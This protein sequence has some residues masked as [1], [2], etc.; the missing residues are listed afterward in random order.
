MA[1]ETFD[2]IIYQA[3]VMYTGDTS[4]LPLNEMIR[5]AA[6]QYLEGGGGSS[7][8]PVAT[9][10]LYVAGRWYP[11]S[12]V[13]TG[14]VAAAS[15][16]VRMCPFVLRQSVT[17]SD[18]GA[19]VTIVGGGSFQLA[20][21]ANNAATMRPTGAVLARTGDILSTSLAAVSGDITGANVLLTA[22]VYWAAVNVDGAS[23]AAAFT[24]PTTISSFGAGLVGSETIAN[25]AA[26]ATSVLLNLTT[27][28]AYN[29]WSDLTAATFTEVTTVVAPSLLIK[30]A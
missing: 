2:E 14:G 26:T 16:T 15:G 12:P 7:G 6:I 13:I 18:L 5:R 25:V 28:L 17:V 3:A 22:G 21:Y 20:I 30:A 8:L 29:T 1:G 10:P 27:P 11:V 23:A 24:G 19:R 9:S 4:G